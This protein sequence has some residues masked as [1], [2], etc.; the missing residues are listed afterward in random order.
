M[1]VAR[2]TQLVCDKC[3]L[4]DDVKPFTVTTP[5]GRTRLD[6]CPRHA[7]PLVEL[8]SAADTTGRT[9]R[10]VHDLDDDGNPIL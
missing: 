6:L 5:Q 3:G 7:K 2:V 9:P 4:A 1:N 10:K 8:V